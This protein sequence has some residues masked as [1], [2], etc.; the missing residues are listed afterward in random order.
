MGLREIVVPL[1]MVVT[2]FFGRRH[3]G[4]LSEAINDFRDNFRGGPPTP[5]HPCP[6]DDGALLRERA[7]KVEN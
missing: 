2:F 7:R 6:A 3:L 4:A 5:M 1:L